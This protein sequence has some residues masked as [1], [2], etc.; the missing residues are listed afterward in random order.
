[1][2]TRPHSRWP[3]STHTVHSRTTGMLENTW[4]R[5]SPGCLFTLHFLRLS[6]LAGYRYVYNYKVVSFWLPPSH[7]HHP[8]FLSPSTHLLFWNLVTLPLLCSLHLH[9][10][11]GASKPSHKPNFSHPEHL[12]SVNIFRLGIIMLSVPLLVQCKSMCSGQKGL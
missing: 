1:M 3:V 7:P 5:A 6:S 8:F 2:V 10:C 9:H 4:W 12:F 11:V